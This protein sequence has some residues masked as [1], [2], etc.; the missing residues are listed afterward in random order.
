MFIWRACHHW[1][2]VMVCLAT[3]NVPCDGVCPW[4]KC[5]PET[6]GHALWGCNSLKSIHKSVPFMAGILFSGADTFLDFFLYCKSRLV[7]NEFELLCV[8]WW[9]IW[10]NRNRCVHGLP[11]LPIEFIVPWSSDFLSQFQAASPSFV[12]NCTTQSVILWSPLP[13]HL[14]K[15]NTDASLDVS[16]GCSSAGV[17][18]RN[19]EGTWSWRVV[20]NSLVLVFLCLL[21]NPWP[22]SEVCSLLYLRVC[23]L[24]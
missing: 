8:V 14:F 21:R 6:I 9:R 23:Y 18:I 3:H 10:F 15:I 1:L 22:F 5:H 13:C 7:Q 24:L 17:V 19:H 11:L 2:P 4:C 12:S 20:L 16:T